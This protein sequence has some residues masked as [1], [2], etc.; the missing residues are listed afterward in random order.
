MAIQGTYYSINHAP[1]DGV[2]TVFEISFAG[3]YISRDHVKA[4]IRNGDIRTEVALS[5]IN[6]FTVQTSIA[7]PMGSVLVIYRDTPKDKPLANFSDGAVITEANLD[8]NAMQAVFIAAEA[9]DRAGGG[10]VSDIGDEYA[11]RFDY[12]IGRISGPALA[13]AMKVLGL[14]ADGQPTLF[15]RD[16]TDLSDVIAR[17]IALEDGSKIT[18]YNAA[19]VGGNFGALGNLA[20][21]LL[22]A[23][24]RGPSQK[25]KFAGVGSSNMKNESGGLA[26]VGKSPV[27]LAMKAAK[28]WL[29]PFGFCE[30]EFQN[31]G[32]NGSAFSGFS[33]PGLDDAPGTNPPTPSPRDRLSTYKP[34]VVIVCYGTNDS[35]TASWNAG[36]TRDYIPIGVQDI[37]DHCARIGADVMFM[38][39]PSAH[40]GKSIPIYHPQSIGVTYPTTSFQVGLGDAADAT[41]ATNVGGANRF[42]AGVAGQFNNPAWGWGLAV[43]KVIAVTDKYFGNTIANFGMYR[44]SAISANGNWIE[45]D[46]KMRLNDQNVLVDDGPASIVAHPQTRLA[47]Q[48]IGI[49]INTE[50]VPNSTNSREEI[51]PLGDGRKIWVLTRYYDLNQLTRTAVANLDN[52]AT[53]ADCEYAYHI[54]LLKDGVT[55]DRYY[56]ALESV[57]WNEL[58]ADEVIAPTFDGIF[59]A[60]S[61]SLRTISNVGEKQFARRFVVRPA[62]QSNDSILALDPNNTRRKLDVMLA[63]GEN[64]V[65]RSPDGRI[66]MEIEW[67]NQ[68]A[69]IVRRIQDANG[70]YRKYRKLTSTNYNIGGGPVPDIRINMPGPGYITGE[71]RGEQMAIGNTLY[72]ITAMW[73]GTTWRITTNKLHTMNNPLGGDTLTFTTNGGDIVITPAAAGTAIDYD[74]EFKAIGTTALPTQ[75]A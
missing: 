18:P 17:L 49:D 4:F 44:I 51:E 41:F 71:V 16:A 6:D 3:G 26:G 13:N 68:T 54:Q 75:D 70:G 46:R 43:G 27:E 55:E 53:L 19:A 10:F 59:R 31:F 32:V 11:L 33:A 15:E 28:Q 40:V 9:L 60:L 63:S 14:D 42:T 20:R 8:T 61:N 35:A 52:P 37:A 36:Q 74:V 24:F 25:I 58:F 50:L 39:V 7:P 56:A 48:R 47:I 1:G 69:N 72:S 23:A 38:T 62:A 5:F 45:V 2:Q 57:H 12:P 65:I 29:D 22:R 67:D 73:D 66:R 64:M 30:W 34:D 21:K